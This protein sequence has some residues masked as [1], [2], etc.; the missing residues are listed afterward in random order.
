MGR[1]LVQGAHTSESGLEA[2][3]TQEY[4]VSQSPI[5]KSFTTN[6]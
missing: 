3:I 1:N 5:Y 6:I 2:K 4:G